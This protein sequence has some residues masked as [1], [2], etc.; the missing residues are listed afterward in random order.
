MAHYIYT[1]YDFQDEDN[2][3]KLENKK[4]RDFVGQKT[5]E[6]LGNILDEIRKNG[7]QVAIKMLKYQ[8]E[9]ENEVYQAL[10]L[11]P[12]QTDA[13][14]KIVNSDTLIEQ[15]RNKL[16]DIDE[17]QNSIKNAE[18]CIKLLGEFFIELLGNYTDLKGENISD[19]KEAVNKLRNMRESFKDYY[20]NLSDEIKDVADR[21]SISIDEILKVA[22]YWNTEVESS[23]KGSKGKVFSLYEESGEINGN[24]TIEELKKVLSAYKGKQNDI[25]GGIGEA[26][27]IFLTKDVRDYIDDNMIRI[28][29][30]G[31]TSRWDSKSDKY[32][33]DYEN[34]V[35]KA[36]EELK[37]NKY[38]EE[39]FD[40]DTSK[41]LKADEVFDIVLTTNDDKIEKIISFGISN[42]T[43]F[44]KGTALKIQETSL[45]SMLTNIFRV[46]SDAYQ[47][48]YNV[49]ENLLT[50]MVNEAGEIAWQGIGFKIAYFNDLIRELINRYAYV[51]FT[52]G[53]SGAG[54]ADF[55]SLYKNGKIYFIPMSVILQEVSV[56]LPNTL[57][58]RGITANNYIMPEEELRV[59]DRLKKKNDNITTQLNKMEADAIKGINKPGRVDLG[60]YRRLGL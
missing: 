53:R 37:N 47:E 57:I 55:F 31:T 28:V 46:E 26:A 52:G 60:N 56:D 15:I 50:L 20:K 58:L 14:G 48:T 54:H 41:N 27:T 25:I 5:R 33:K 11:T 18:E 3:V 24:L 45:S 44:S 2:N 6:K 59:L 49:R 16:Y 51:W 38:V 7:E 29:T 13:Q 1:L 4:I 35:K 40:L 21:N 36:I 42:K 39:I 17:K 19:Y 30:K 32:K 34:T 8:T 10:G 22:E 9:R 23:L 43:G 12:I